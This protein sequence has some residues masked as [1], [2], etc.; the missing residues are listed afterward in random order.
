M[1]NALLE[2]LGELT[3][4]QWNAPSLCA[5]WRVRDV[6]SHLLMPYELSPPRFLAGLVANRFDFDRMANAWALRDHRTASELT[7][8]LRA[9][10]KFRV[11]G[12]GPE[13]ELTHMVI[14][15]LDIAYPL[16]KSYAVPPEAANLTLDQLFSPR[17]RGLVDADRL[18]GLSF[19]TTDTGWQ[20]GEGPRVEAPA[21][22]LILT[23]ANRPAALPDLTGDGVPRLAAAPASRP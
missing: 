10:G 2:L 5:G 23:I 4:D 20:H 3:P 7:A 1:D 17:A 21:A 22:S 12:A 8:A 9:R 13:G 14:H 11:P 18:A 16:G 15:G 19:A 6:V